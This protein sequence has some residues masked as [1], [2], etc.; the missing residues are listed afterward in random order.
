MARR[1]VEALEEHGVPCW[2]APR[3]I[4]PGDNYTQAILDALAAAPALVLVFSSAADTSPHV[5]REL[6][7]AVGSDTAI[8]PVRLE[9][10]D[11]SAAL[12]Y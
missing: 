6:E 2:I 4:A 9:A 7:M 12:G 1:V 11:P 10:K 3:D 8:V 5:R